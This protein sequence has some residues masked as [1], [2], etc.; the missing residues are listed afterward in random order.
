M[1]IKLRG[2]RRLTPKEAARN[3]LQSLL[4]CRFLG[5]RD[6]AI[7]AFVENSLV[8]TLTNVNFDAVKVGEIKYFFVIGGW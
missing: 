7:V 6:K 2:T 5:A 8:T 4:T 1:I 3:I